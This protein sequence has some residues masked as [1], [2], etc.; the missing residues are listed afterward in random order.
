MPFRGVVGTKT[1]CTE[2]NL[3]GKADI[4]FMTY[5]H[6]SRDRAREN[7]AYGLIW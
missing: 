3:L 7:S 6:G 2:C 1:L 4:P 5:S